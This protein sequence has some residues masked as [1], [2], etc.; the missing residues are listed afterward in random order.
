MTPGLKA[1]ISFFGLLLLANLNLNQNMMYKSHMGLKT[2]DI[3]RLNQEVPPI[4]KEQALLENYL[5]ER[6]MLI[7]CLIAFILLPLILAL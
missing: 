2:G 7:C 4:F 1:T 3:M 5:N 6:F